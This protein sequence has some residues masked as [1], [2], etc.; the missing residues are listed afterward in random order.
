ME[1]VTFEEPSVIETIGEGAFQG[2]SA[3][4]RIELPVSVTTIEKDA[5]NT[6]K[7][8]TEIVIPKNVSSI[9]PTGFQECAKLEKFTVD[10]NNATYSSVDGFLLSKDKKVLKAFPPAK[11]NTYYT[12]LPPTLEEIGT[13]AFY[14]V[15]ALENITIP[16]NVKK[17]DKFAF[18]RTAKL[19]TIAFLGKTPITNID[20]SAFN[21]ANV[22]T[23]NI[24]ISIRKEALAAFA[25]DHFWDKFK[26]VGISFFKET[27]GQGYGSTEFFPLSN[28][29]VMVVDVKADVYTYV[30]PNT[31][32]NA[33]DHDKMYEVRLWGDYAMKQN[34]TNIKEIVFRNT[35][36]YVGLDA[37]NKVRT[38]HLTV[39][40]Y[41]LQASTLQRI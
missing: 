19:N 8:L 23:H 12:L 30:V 26:Q 29:A 15:Q 35:L 27:N 17:I 24:Q 32:E 6:C 36:D 18:D 9:D 2:A 14:Y 13:Q 10:K 41:S 3:L 1:K 5:F 20:P 25:A 33:D 7:S 39:K 38:A 37:F 40:A 11:A 4:K 21:P 28:K 31:V 16:E 22:N 34:T